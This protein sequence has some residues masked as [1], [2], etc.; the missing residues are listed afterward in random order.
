MQLLPVQPDSRPD[1]S[2]R[3]RDHAQWLARHRSY[4]KVSQIRI[5][6]LHSTLRDKRPGHGSTSLE[7]H[8][9]DP[10]LVI[11]VE[12]LLYQRESH[13]LGRTTRFWPGGDVALM[14]CLMQPLLDLVYIHSLDCVTVFVIVYYLLLN[15]RSPTHILYFEHLTIE[16]VP[17]TKIWG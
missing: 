6:L 12:I 2:N 9:Y 4:S 3:D 5:L 10:G 7:N 13:L 1:Y 14:P 16:Q 17:A 15:S 8:S 11:F